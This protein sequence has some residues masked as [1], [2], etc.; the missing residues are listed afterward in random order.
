MK[1]KGGLCFRLG[2]DVGDPRSQD[3]AP[4]QDATVSAIVDGKRIMLARITALKA[5][6]SA[7]TAR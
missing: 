5:K 7:S 3:H 2:E 1:S 6:T 4:G